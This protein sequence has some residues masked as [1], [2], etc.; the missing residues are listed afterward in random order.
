MLH[1]VFR[2]ASYGLSLCFIW[3]LAPNVCWC[4]FL[5]SLYFCKEV[6]DLLF[7]QRIMAPAVS[8][9]LLAMEV[10]V[11]FQASPFAIFGGRNGTKTLL[12][13][14]IRG[15]P[16]RGSW[17]GQFAGSPLT[18]LQLRIPIFE[19]R[20]GN[21]VPLAGTCRILRSVLLLWL[22]KIPI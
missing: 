3:F 1:M 13:W 7:P 12:T 11:E 10:T 14:V 6:L 8:G 19:F 9:R 18:F 2:Y 5:A 16:H 21:R 4:Y 17:M 22:K 20:T 15:F